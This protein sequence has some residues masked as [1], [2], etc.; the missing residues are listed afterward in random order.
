MYETI[1]IPTDGSSDAMKGARQG[2]GLAASLDATVH[3]LFVVKHG[4][5][6]WESSSIDDQRERAEAYGLEV[7]GEVADLAEEA[8]VE[9]VEAVRFGPHVY[10]VINDYVE[11]ADVD[12]IAM[13]SG[14][15]GEFGGLFGSTADK[16]LRTAHVPVLVLR[17][18]LRQ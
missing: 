8:G 1:L 16:V 17:R 15:Q 7:V 12:L 4:T 13:C 11:E 5:N 2:I 9:F 10:E 6:P 14:Y 3:G 18:E